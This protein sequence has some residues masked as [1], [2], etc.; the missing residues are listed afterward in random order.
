MISAIAPAPPMKF[1]FPL[2]LA[3]A[4]V[5]AALPARA[6]P[7]SVTVVGPDGKP[8]PNATLSVPEPN[9]QKNAMESRQITGANGV[10]SFDWD[11]KFPAPGKPAQFGEVPFVRVQAP[12]MATDIEILTAPATQV[13]LK[14]GRVWRGVVL[15]QNEM[16]VAGVR[17]SLANIF[18]P[19][20]NI[21]TTTGADGRWQLNDLPATGEAR[22]A[23]SDPRFVA[24]N[25][26][27]K[28]IDGEAPPLFVKRAATLTGQIVKPDGTP[29]VGAPVVV[30]GGDYENL[31]HTDAAGRFTLGGVKPGKV[32]LVSFDINQIRAG[33]ITKSGDYLL[34]EFPNI[35]AVG[36]Q[37]TDIGQWRASAGA[38]VTMRALDAATGKPI[39]GVRFSSWSGNSA[40]PSDARGLIRA[41]VLPGADTSGPYL[42]QIFSERYVGADVPRPPVLGKTGVTD[43]GTIKMQRGTKVRGRARISGQTFEDSHDL[44]QLELGE[45]NNSIG[46]WV[47]PYDNSFQT[48]PLAPG[49]Y[50]IRIVAD[51]GLD[52]KIWQLISPPTL[53]VAAPGAALTTAAS[54]LEII[55]KRLVPESKPRPNI[56]EVRGRLLDVNGKGVGGA[57]VNV[58]LPVGPSQ[59]EITAVTDRN[60]NWSAPVG[61]R[62]TSIKL[63]SVE[64]PGYLLSGTARSEINAGVATISGVSLKRS[65]TIFA[66]RVTDAEG[67][68]AA[69]AWVV[70]VEARDLAP[71]QT[72]ADGTFALRDVPLEHFTLLAARG[73]DYVRAPAQASDTKVELKLGKPRPFDRAALVAQALDG[74]LP[75]GRIFDYWDVLGAARMEALFKN[76]G[77]RSGTTFPLELARR[78]PAAFVARAPSLMQ[79]LSAD[80]KTQLEAAL[81]L[82]RAG[83]PDAPGKLAANAWVD[84]GKTAKRAIDADNV[85]QLLRVAA[86]A[87]RL[88]RADADGLSD[89]AAAIAA[90]LGGGSETKAEAWGDLAAQSGFA[91]TRNLAEG[92]K[93]IAEFK[94]WWSATGPIARAGDFAGAKAALAR[95]ETLAQ[96]P[97]WKQHTRLQSWDDPAPLIDQ[98][99]AQ[100]AR[101]MAPT[102]LAGAQAVAAQIG[103]DYESDQ[104]QLA[105]ADAALKTGDPAAATLALRAAMSGNYLNPEHFALAA[106]L[107][108]EVGPPLSDELW[109]QA[110]ARAL[111]DPQSGGSFVSS[112]AMWAF[113]HARLDAAQSRVTIEREWN[114]RLATALAKP[115]AN[116]QNTPGLDAL[117]MAMAAVDPARALEMRAQAK[118]VKAPPTANLG[119]AA[120]LLMSDE[121]RARWGVDSDY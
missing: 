2:A 76:G 40:A 4:L 48:Q 115:S 112:V 57:V 89:Y 103:A 29:I 80:E 66:G 25:Y 43:L 20:W 34:K 55:V 31:V 47:N 50:R 117:E 116:D 81:M 41:R 72:K 33:I 84:E 102:D 101:A 108:Q 99:R 37:T 118:A 60:G 114:W 26:A 93:P 30:N 38:V 96:T 53:T 94:L 45:I 79:G 75:E 98:V 59:S 106:S 110:Y 58:A 42:G 77:W 36:G 97:A 49:N 107:A 71:V 83:L 54:P 32:M 35:R 61:F 21:E 65:G 51:S 1:A 90:Q 44:P 68:P 24:A 14:P 113:Y 73:S 3:L 46:L 86:V 12:G 67:N 85:T 63:K 69:G 62:P 19:A 52:S 28:V 109:A 39:E 92:L 64:R 56:R 8:L 100:V 120:A 70:V 17:V 91:A 18:V 10:F 23:L 82:A 27:L 88:G 11:G 95:M 7:V 111:P 121:E 78:D 105:L 9:A 16:P 5:C 22:I 13:A 6:V 87:H 104:A 15:D 74:R 119:L